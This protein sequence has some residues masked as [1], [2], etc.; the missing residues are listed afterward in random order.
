VAVHVCVL[1]KLPFKQAVAVPVRVKPALHASE[2]LLPEERT[3]EQVPRVPFA[4][5]DT[6]HAFAAHDCAVKTPLLQDV[7]GP[8][9]LK[10]ELHAKEQ[11]LPEARTDGQVPM[12]PFAGADTGHEIPAA[13]TEIGMLKIVRLKRTAASHRPV[14][15]IFMVFSLCPAAI[16]LFQ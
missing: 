1:I 16:P 7:T 10:P 8:T 5:A 2:Q 12:K 14:I 9:R 15:L 3:D 13:F 6:T 11:V 4:G